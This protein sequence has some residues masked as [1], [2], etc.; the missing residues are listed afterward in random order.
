MWT[1]LLPISGL[2]WLAVQIRNACYSFGWMSPRRLD[3]FV[4]S[5]GNLTVG[6]TGKTPTVIWIAQELCKRGF[7]VAILSRGYS[8][9]GTRPQLVSPGLSDGVDDFGDEPAMMARIFGLTVAVA[10]RRYQAADEILQA[11]AVDALLLDDGFQHRQ[12]ARDVDLLLL[13][14]D[15]EGWMLPAGPF[16]EPKTALGRAD[17]LLITGARD[18]WQRVMGKNHRQP[19]FY[20]SLQPQALIGLE[21]HHWQEYSLNRLAR[22]KILAV[23]GIA[24]PEPF[25]RMIEV[26]KGEIVEIVAFPD[27]HHYTA[28]DGQRIAWAARN[29]DLIVTTEKD[30][31]K[32]V[33]FSFAGKELLAL[34]VAMIVESGAALLQ[35]V[36]E[37]IQKK[38][39]RHRGCG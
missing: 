19:V 22:R 36:V 15:L 39:S 6:G 23:T 37:H 11:G 38:Q 21:S 1:L 12:L 20:G 8:R 13:G 24:N 25:Y 9:K 27:H 28:K 35:S 34:R 17:F 5:I 4:I 31:L 29:A 26:S 33:R 14:S 3:P 10:S 32:L 18:G 16:R 30:I 2:Y 7:K